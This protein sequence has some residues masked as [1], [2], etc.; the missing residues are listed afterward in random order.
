MEENKINMPPPPKEL[1]NMPPP[2]PKFGAGNGMPVPP[3]QPP[4]QEASNEE[5]VAAVPVVENVSKTMENTA[6]SQVEVKTEYAKPEEKKKT[7][8]VKHKPVGGIRTFLY[9]LGFVLSLGAVGV[10]IYLLVK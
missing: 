10:L 9:W 2:P 5:N 8:K 6:V 1:R 7:E 3:P 4:K